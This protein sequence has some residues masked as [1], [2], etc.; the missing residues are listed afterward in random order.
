M[1]CSR[2]MISM[3]ATYRVARW[4]SKPLTRD[5][6]PSN[7]STARHRFDLSCELDTATGVGQPSGSKQLPF[8]SH[9]QDTGHAPVDKVLLP[10]VGFSLRT[11]LSAA[12]AFRSH[13]SPV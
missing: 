3:R 5:S 1:Q 12:A 4:L 9:P 13:A 7:G 2:V 10:T 6:R 11:P 8:S